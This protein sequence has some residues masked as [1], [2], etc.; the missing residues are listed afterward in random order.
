MTLSRRVT[1]EPKKVRG[2]EEIKKEGR[3]I[4]INIQEEP[5]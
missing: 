4:K 1:N 2:E 5:L 3:E